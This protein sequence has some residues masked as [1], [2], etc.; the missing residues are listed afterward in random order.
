MSVTTSVPAAVAAA[1]RPPPSAYIHLLVIYVVWGA[2][3][4]AVKLSLTGPAS[5]TVLQLQAGRL[6]AAGLLLAA[7]TGLRAGL[8]RGIRPRDLATCASSGIMLWVLGNGLATLA[9]RHAASSFIVMALGTIPLWTAALD[10]VLG[11]RRPETTTLGALGLGF[12]GLALVLAPALSAAGAEV[13]APGY[14][15]VTIVVLAGAGLFWSLGTI[16]QRPVTGRVDIGWIACLQML[17][18]ALALTPALLVEGAPVPVG[19][20]FTQVSA[21]LFL[22]V[23]ASV[24]AP[25]SFIQ[26]VRVFSPAVASTFAYVNPIVGVAL[27]ALVLGEPISIVSLSGMAMVFLA[28]VLILRRAR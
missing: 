17:A 16:L 26:V 25:L 5:V 21:F 14:G 1:D 2:A 27:G 11:S 18:S 22:V 4:F 6:W 9:S 20:S 3:Y 23:L 13:V 15:P 10:F 12:V 8:P 7:V 24:V 28:I 19:P